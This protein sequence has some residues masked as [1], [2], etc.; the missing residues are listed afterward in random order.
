MDLRQ[1]LTAAGRALDCA[2]DAVLA[3]GV[4]DV[5]YVTRTARTAKLGSM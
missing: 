1:A 5:S 4:S 2:R 3:C